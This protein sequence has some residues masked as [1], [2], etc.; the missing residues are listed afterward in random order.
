MWGDM[1]Y[2]LDNSNPPAPSGQ[3]TAGSTW[4]FQYWFRDPNTGANFN[5]SNGHSITFCP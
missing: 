1:I 5:L 3:L 4:N 2:S